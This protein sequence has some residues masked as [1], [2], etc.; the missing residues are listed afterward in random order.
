MICM[1]RNGA[2]FNAKWKVFYPDCRRRVVFCNS[3]AG[4]FVAAI[5]VCLQVL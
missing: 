1:K 3:G 4:A 2:L 5:T